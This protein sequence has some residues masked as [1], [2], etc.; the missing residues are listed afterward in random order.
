VVAGYLCSA[1]D[2]ARGI[3]TNSGTPAG[4]GKVT[5]LHAEL[6]QIAAVALQWAAAIDRRA[7]VPP[8]PVVP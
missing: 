1:G 3:L 6:I 8:S 5:D 4:N 7:G 2:T